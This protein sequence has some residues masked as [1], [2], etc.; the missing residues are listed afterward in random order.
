[1]FQSNAPIG[2]VIPIGRDILP[3]ADK[4]NVCIRLLAEDVAKL[5]EYYEVRITKSNLI[6]ALNEILN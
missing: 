1:M 6:L 4:Y 3:D 2:D 5:S